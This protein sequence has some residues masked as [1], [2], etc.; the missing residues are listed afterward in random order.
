MLSRS[1]LS[2]ISFYTVLLLVASGAFRPG[3]L[4]IM[5]YRE[6]SVQMLRDL[7]VHKTRL[8][9]TVTLHQNK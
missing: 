5:N 3:V 7:S 8:V 4:E 1:P 9:I 2:R 6:V